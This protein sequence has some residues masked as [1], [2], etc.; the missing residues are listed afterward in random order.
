MNFDLAT[1]EISKL[2][3]QKWHREYSAKYMLHYGIK[4]NL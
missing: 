3:A 1:D 2:E 4:M